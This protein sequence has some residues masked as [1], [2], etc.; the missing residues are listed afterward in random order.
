MG[1]AENIDKIEGLSDLEKDF[2]N[3]Y[4]YVAKKRLSKL[5]KPHTA[6]YQ[7][8]QRWLNNHQYIVFQIQHFKNL[9]LIKNTNDAFN[10]VLN[11]CID[12]A[13]D[14]KK[15]NKNKIALESLNLLQK[16]CGLESYAQQTIAN[17][18]QASKQSDLAKLTTQQLQQLANTVS[19]NLALLADNK[20]NR[21]EREQCD[22]SEH[23][24]SDIQS[25]IVIDKLNKD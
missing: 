6:I 7:K 17:L 13:V 2:L 14:A 3:Q 10:F 24:V 21:A 4:F 1:Y 18:N 19:N 12:I 15:Q 25:A 8:W 9:N 23:C 16:I 11:N 22:K 5:Y 20:T